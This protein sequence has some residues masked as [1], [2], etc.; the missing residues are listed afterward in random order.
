MMNTS[1]KTQIWNHAKQTY[2][3]ATVSIMIDE[4]KI[5]ERLARKA[6]I[7]KSKRATAMHGNITVRIVSTEEDK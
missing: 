5:I 1:Y 6:L 7:S 3:N 4:R 2:V